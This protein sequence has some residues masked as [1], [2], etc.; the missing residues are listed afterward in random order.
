MSP[1]LHPDDVKAIAAQLAP[2]IVAEL[3]RPVLVTGA[4]PPAG[5]SAVELGAR[6]RSEGRAYRQPKRA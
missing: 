1:R 6:L 2:L 4:V 3:R 5:L